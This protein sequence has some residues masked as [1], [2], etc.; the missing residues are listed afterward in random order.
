[1]HHLEVALMNTR[2]ALLGILAGTAPVG[3]GGCHQPVTEA[4]AL[5]QPLQQLQAGNE[6]FVAGRTWHDHQNLQRCMETAE[7]GQHPFATVLACSDSR[8][9][10]EELFDQGIGD[11]FIVRVAGNVSGQDETGSIEYGTE[12]LHTPLLVVLGHRECGAVTAA[13]KGAEAHGSIPALLAHIEPAVKRA[14]KDNPKAQGDELVS[15]AVQ[16]NVWH[17][18]EELLEHSA[19]LRELVRDG[20]VTIVGAVYDIRSA[21]V[22]W[23]GHHPAEKRLLADETAHASHG[24]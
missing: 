24:S 11:L 6:R 5:Q 15:F 2:I 10:V 21:K 14:Q 8:V 19:D 4:V 13:V 17:S 9:P 23:L 22:E 18:I 1:L 16:A 7:K 20:K 3:V 12:H